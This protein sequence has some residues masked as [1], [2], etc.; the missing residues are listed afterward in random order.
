M[1]KRILNQFHI[2][3]L[4]WIAK[5]EVTP[6]SINIWLHVAGAHMFWQLVK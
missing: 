1:I 4:Q 5:I 6:T 3:H 2:L